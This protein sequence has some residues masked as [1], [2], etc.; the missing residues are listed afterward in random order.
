[1][2]RESFLFY[3]LPAVLWT[4]A[5]LGFVLADHWHFPLFVLFLMTPWAWVW[6]L[7]RAGLWAEIAEEWK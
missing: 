3:A 6:A 5:A 2:I 4:A 7:D 1:M